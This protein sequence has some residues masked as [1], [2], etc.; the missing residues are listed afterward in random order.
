[1]AVLHYLWWVYTVLLRVQHGD[2]RCRLDCKLVDR[3]D[4]RPLLGR[5]ACLGTRIVSYHDNDKLNKPDTRGAPIY[6]VGESGP[7][8]TQQLIQQNPTVFSD[9]VGLLEGQYHIR[10]DE[11]TT[12]VQHA[13]RRIPVPLREELQC[14]LADMTQQGIIAP[15]QRQTPWISSM[16][17]V[18]KQNGTLRIC[19]YRSSVPQPCNST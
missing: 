1:M 16:V 12:P 7:L 14:T 6:S 3:T 4:I 19:L 15:V 8:S 2:F 18:P 10:L 5:K 11:S 17:T 9:G 13:P